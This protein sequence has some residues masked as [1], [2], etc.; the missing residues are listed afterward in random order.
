MP[1]MIEWIACAAMGVVLGVLA[2]GWPFYGL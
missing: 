2:A 1:M